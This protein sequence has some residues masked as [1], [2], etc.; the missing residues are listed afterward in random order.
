MYVYVHVLTCVRANVQDTLSLWRY[1]SQRETLRSCF[2]L[3]VIRL[4]GKHHYLV[5][6]SLPV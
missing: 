1:G 6:H 5:S 4:G 2:C 3:P